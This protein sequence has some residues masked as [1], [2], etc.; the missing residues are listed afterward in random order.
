MKARGVEI[1]IPQS[2][3]DWIKAET[4]LGNETLTKKVAETNDPD[5]THALAWSKQVN[6]DVKAMV[7]GVSPFPFV[8]ESFEQL[9]GQADM[10]VVSATPNEALKAEWDE[11]DVTKYVTAI[12]GQ[13]SGSKKETLANASKYEANHTLMIG[14]AP[15]D[16]RAA[17][18]NNCLFYPIN[19][20]DEEASWER[21]NKEGVQKFLAGEFAGE[22][23]EM[24]LAEFDKYLP[25]K[26][27]WKSL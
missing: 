10:L 26:P 9:S 15:G 2:L 22:Y 4:A 8:R 18:A 17:V 14:D 6:V 25:E 3:R 27:S 23:Q 20:G 16:Y 24:L 13:E 19:P 7:E 11:H 1:T 12:C 21:F 5:L